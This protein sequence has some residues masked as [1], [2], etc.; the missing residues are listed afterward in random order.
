[1]ASLSDL[2]RAATGLAGPELEHLH[3]LVGEWQLLADLSFADLLLLVPD[4]RCPGTHLCVAQVRPATGPTVHAEDLVGVRFPAGARVAVAA[5]AEQGRIVREGDPVWRGE[6]PVREEALPVRAAPGGMVAAVL[7]RDTNV[8][9][10]RTPSALDLAYLATASD[11]AQMVADGRFPLPGGPE[12][13]PNAPRVGDGMMRLDPDGTVAFASPNAQSALRRLGFAGNL[14]GADLRAVLAGLGLPPYPAQERPPPLDREL[15]AADGDA[16]VRLRALPLL[17]GGRRVGVLVLL[18]DVTEVRRR[19]RELLTKDATIREI[20]HRVKNNLQTV[21]ALLRLQ[22][23]RTPVPAARS[24]LEE[25]VRRVTAIAVVHETLSRSL[26]EA[27]DF[28]PVA[29]TIAAL[30]VDLATTSTA[31][32][33][34][35]TRV[36]SFGVLPSQVA[37]LLALVL[38]ELVSNAVEH[39]YDGGSGAVAVRVARSAAGLEMVVADDGAGLRERFA[40]PDAGGLGLQ[41]VRTLVVGELR[42]TFALRPGPLRGTEA[43]IAVAGAVLAGS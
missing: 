15:V 39:G 7:A 38:S 24:A 33:A 34:V 26:A 20:H 27:V 14:L 3:L 22:A 4:R 21:A 18:R 1:V 19:D 28:D 10:L 13:L 36:G 6:V 9:A 35:P 11:L 30:S 8:A 17:P 43:V 32:R 12:V 40:L 2:V 5:A 16:T 29:D 31:A 25:S 37:T 41:I 23:R 42:G